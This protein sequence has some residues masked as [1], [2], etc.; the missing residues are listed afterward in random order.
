MTEKYIFSDSVLSSGN[1]DLLLSDKSLAE[2]L[3][4]DRHDI[5]FRAVY[6]EVMNGFSE[7]NLN[8]IVNANGVFSGI[9]AFIEIY[10]SSDI[11]DVL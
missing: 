8:A 3:K 6:E 1:E 10:E 9:S 4:K 11:S 7:C 2:I 5:V